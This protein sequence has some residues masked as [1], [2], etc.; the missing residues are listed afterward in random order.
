MDPCSTRS[1]HDL[2]VLDAKRTKEKLVAARGVGSDVVPSLWLQ[3]GARCLGLFDLA[4]GLAHEEVLAAAA[5]IIAASDAPVAIM[6]REGFAL[7]PED[8]AK[9]E[10]HVAHGEHGDLAR[11]FAAGD[12]DIAEALI[13]ATVGADSFVTS[14]HPYRYDGRSVRWGE[15]VLSDEADGAVPDALRGGYEMRSRRP[16]PALDVATIAARSG[17]SVY[18]PADPPRNAPCPCGSGR[19]VKACCWA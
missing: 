7:A 5:A 4:A 2:A 11:R 15:T 9:I 3:R 13:L 18:V 14:Y 12:P 1:I 19:K 16:E 10:L 8:P 6:V 17:L